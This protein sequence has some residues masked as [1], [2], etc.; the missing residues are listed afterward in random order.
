MVLPNF[1][2]EITRMLSYML[3]FCMAGELKTLNDG[4]EYLGRNIATVLGKIV[5]E[6][7]SIGADRLM[8]GPLGVIMGLIRRNVTGTTSFQIKFSGTLTVN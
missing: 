5:N 4:D 8:L 2:A 6:G 1:L 3:Y 7:F